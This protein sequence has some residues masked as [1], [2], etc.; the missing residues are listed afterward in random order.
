MS[1]TLK[2]LVAEYESIP[3]DKRATKYKTFIIPVFSYH[4]YV[5]EVHYE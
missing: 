4:F 3:Y 2:Y 5:D 1:C